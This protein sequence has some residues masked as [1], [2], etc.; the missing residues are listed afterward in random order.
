MAAPGPGNRNQT[1]LNPAS[2]KR[3]TSPSPSPKTNQIYSDSSSRQQAD[4]QRLVSLSRGEALSNVVQDGLGYLAQQASRNLSSANNSAKNKFIPNINKFVTSI[5]QNIQDKTNFLPPAQWQDQVRHPSGGHTLGPVSNHH[6]VQAKTTSHQR[7]S[8]KIS[9]SSG[10]QNAHQQYHHHIL[11]N[12]MILSADPSVIKEFEMREMQS[13]STNS[14]R[15][16]SDPKDRLSIGQISSINPGG[17]FDVSTESYDDLH[18]IV[19]YCWRLLSEQIDSL[20]RCLPKEKSLHSED[21]IF[22]AL[23]QLKKVRDVLK[24]SLKLEDELESAGPSTTGPGSKE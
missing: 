16:K 5:G 21:E 4:K 20:Q 17:A 23:A 24:G 7:A 19:D 12:D 18:S 3:F 9:S 8:T 10:H 14:L 15:T 6:N 13:T 22:V 2:T 1:I 11:P